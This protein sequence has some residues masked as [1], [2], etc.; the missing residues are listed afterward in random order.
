V[1]PFEDGPVCQDL[2]GG[3]G[4]LEVGFGEDALDASPYFCIC[5]VKEGLS[6][7]GARYEVVMCVLEG[8]CEVGRVC[9]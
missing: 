8:V 5:C 1:A 4:V 3:G 2:G 9:L 6:M 7:V